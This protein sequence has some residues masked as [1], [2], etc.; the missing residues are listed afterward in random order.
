MERGLHQVDLAS[1]L[2]VSKV[3][4][5]KWETDKSRPRLRSLERLVQVL[6]CAVSD[7]SSDAAHAGAETPGAAEILL[8]DALEVYKT[9]IAKLAGARSKDVAITISFGG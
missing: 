1:R 8:G 3:T 4:V 2:G 9:E 5:W 7:L 6:E